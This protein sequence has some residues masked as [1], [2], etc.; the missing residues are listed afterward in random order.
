MRLPWLNDVSTDLAAPPPF[1]ASAAARAA[2]GGFTHADPSP[3]IR[4]AQRRAYPGVQ[5]TMLDLDPE[6]AYKL[7]L[8]TVQARRWRIIEATP[9]KGRFGVGHIDAVATSRIMG[10]PAD[11]A[12]RIRPKGARPASICARPRGWS[13]R[14]RHQC[15]PD[16]KL[17]RTILQNAEVSA[18]RLGVENLRA[19]RRL[20]S[21]APP[22]TPA[23]D[24]VDEMRQH[25]LGGG[26]AQGGSKVAVS[27]RHDGR[28]RWCR[29][30]P[31]SAGSRPRA[32]AGAPG[33]R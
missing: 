20:R 19:E 5:P 2:R 4:D 7:V 31:D 15:G 3:Q 30:R 10:L 14:T 16:R 26:A 18:L 21:F 12:I 32:I 28:R 13:G 33:G 6:A 27:M 17:Q 8:Q 1:S 22:R 23:L 25:R 11:V 29:P 24:E 9:P